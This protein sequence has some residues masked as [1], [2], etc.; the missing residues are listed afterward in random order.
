VR[1]RLVAE[2]RVYRDDLRGHE[3]RVAHVAERTLVD[4]T[5]G[6]IDVGLGDR[7]VRVCARI[8]HFFSLVIFFFSSLFFQ[9]TEQMVAHGAKARGETTKPTRGIV[10]QLE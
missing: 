10:S 3:W 4:A 9:Q 2:R 8:R 5:E 1:E 6:R 7:A